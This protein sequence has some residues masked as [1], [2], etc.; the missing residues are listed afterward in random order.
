MLNENINL[1][2]SNMKKVVLLVRCSTDKERGL[3][4]YQYQI[5]TLTEMC[6][7][8]GWEIV[9]IFGNYVSGAAPLEE[10]QEVLDLITYVK[11]NQI[12]YCCATSIDRVSRD[13][14]TGVQIIRTL[15]ENG[16][17][18]YLL[19]YNIFS[20]DERSGKISPMTELMLSVTLSVS[21]YERE[22]IRQR[23]SMGYKAYC[24]RRKSNPEL[25]LGR[26]GYKKDEQSYRQDYAHEL[27]LLRK[28]IS[29]R[30]V[31]KLTGTSLGTLQK[32]KQYL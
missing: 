21:S 16:V 25:R 28:G 10:R 7:N 26:Q 14:L 3:Q 6:E 30:N 1:A 13:L 17:N 18:L 15:A 24:Q 5:D 29:M 32:I 11:E 22:Q 2:N 9:K 12:D 27:S 20:L 8:R 31:Q 23:L 19:N 4:D